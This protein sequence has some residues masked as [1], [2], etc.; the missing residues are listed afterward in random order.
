MRLLNTPIIDLAKLYVCIFK[1]IKL[2]QF[3]LFIA[4]NAPV[5]CLLV[6]TAPARS[7]RRWGEG[8]A[9]LIM[10]SPRARRVWALLETAYNNGM[11]NTGHKLALALET[12]SEISGKVMDLRVLMAKMTEHQ[13]TL[14][15]YLVKGY[16]EL[17]TLLLAGRMEELAHVV[18][19]VTTTT[20]T[21]IKTGA[22][23]ALSDLKQLEPGSLAA[24]E[25][26][27]REHVQASI[28]TFNYQQPLEDISWFFKLLAPQAAQIVT[29][30]MED[31]K[32]AAQTRLTAANSLLD[33]AGYRPTESIKRVELPVRV[34]INPP[35]TIQQGEVVKGTA[36]T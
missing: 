5:P 16:S 12:A 9:R 22:L 34:I 35:P 23:R 31:T 19:V 18:P 11:A 3:L 36:A 25:K 21:M 6:T 33:R 13:R 26:L 1:Y 7:P 4:R 2:L 15:A 30:I 28:G 29:E 8:R 17:E 32:V 27:A 20:G 10:S 14:F 24:L